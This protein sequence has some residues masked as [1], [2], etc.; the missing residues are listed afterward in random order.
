MLSTLGRMP[1]PVKSLLAVGFAQRLLKSLIDRQPEG[2]SDNVRRKVKGVLI[3]VARNGKGDIGWVTT[4]DGPRSRP[5][6]VTLQR[7]SLRV[8][9]RLVCDM[10]P[11]FGGYARLQW[12]D[13]QDMNV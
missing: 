8:N 10:L 3:G 5:T 6:S 2:P 13:S 1:G 11:A 12:G 7:V 4:P 9:T